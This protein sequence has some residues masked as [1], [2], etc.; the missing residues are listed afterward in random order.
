L[1]ENK[2]M[3]PHKISLHI[4]EKLTIE[5]LSKKI[6][7]IVGLKQAALFISHFERQYKDWEVT[8]ECIRHFKGLEVVYKKGFTKEERADLSPKEIR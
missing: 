2:K 3:M 6:S 8:E 4:E 7:E 5:Q 1:S